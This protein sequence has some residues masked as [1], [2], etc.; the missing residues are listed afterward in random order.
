M[1][2]IFPFLTTRAVVV[3]VHECDTG[4]G[5]RLSKNTLTFIPID[6]RCEREQIK[7]K[8]VKLESLYQVAAVLSVAPVTLRSS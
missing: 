1:N 4:S 8:K 2:E 7:T 3:L 5:S 6:S